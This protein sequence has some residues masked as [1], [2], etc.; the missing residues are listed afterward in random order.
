[1]GVR[2]MEAGQR[3]DKQFQVSKPDKRIPGLQHSGTK[4]LL[5]V[6]QGLGTMPRLTQAPRVRPATHTPTTHGH[7][8]EQ[9]HVA[10]SNKLTSCGGRGEGDMQ[11]GNH[12]HKAVGLA[13][14]PPGAL[15]QSRQTRTAQLVPGGSWGCGHCRVVSPHHPVISADPARPPACPS[16]VHVVPA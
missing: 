9:H 7:L 10:W 6:C 2:I 1:M 8:A 14:Q 16:Q 12:P 3:G 4:P 5:Y 15:D 11:G 13:P